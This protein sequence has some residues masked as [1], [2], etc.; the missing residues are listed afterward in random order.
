MNQ[1]S[2]QDDK[3]LPQQQ[4]IRLKD[5]LWFLTLCEG[6]YKPVLSL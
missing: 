6:Q 1:V 3:H 5:A 4:M 2:L